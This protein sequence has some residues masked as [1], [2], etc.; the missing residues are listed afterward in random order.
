A[1][2]LPCN[3]SPQ[4]LLQLRQIAQGREVRIGLRLVAQLE[5]LVLVEI[6]RGSKRLERAE[7]IAR[8]GARRREV[9]PGLRMAGVEH[10]RALEI[11]D[12][13]LGS[14]GTQLFEPRLVAG[15]RLMHALVDLVERLLRASG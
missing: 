6:D 13:E 3:S 9:V 12:R 15:V 1:P 11:V 7:R 10:H 5:G 4:D 8:G 2:F 14:A